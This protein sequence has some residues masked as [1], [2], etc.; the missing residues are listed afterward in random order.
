MTS[1]QQRNEPRRR[2]FVLLTTAVLAVALGMPA[3]LASHPEVSL[4]GSNFEIDTDANLKMDDATPSIDWASVTETRRNDS[5]SGAN[6]ESFGQ[7]TKE[8]TTVPVVVDGGIPPNKSDL[9]AFGVYQEGA[10]S[11]GF[12]NLF[13]SR[14]QDPS[15]TTNMDFE[16]NKNRC[17]GAGCS[18]NGVTP[19]RTAGD[20]LVIYD[21][22]QGGTHPTLSIRRWTGS[23]WGPPTDLSAA[24]DAAGSINTSAIPSADSD[25]LGAL[26]PRTFGEAQLDLAAI[27]SGSTTCTSFGSAYLKSRSSDSFTAALKDFV[28]PVG[29][30]ISNCG[31]VRILKTDDA[32]PANPLSGAVF[33]AYKDAAPTGGSRGAEDSVSAGTCTT[34]AAG[35]CTISSLLTGPYWIVETTTP[36]GFDTAAPQ[37]VD[38]T[39]SQTVTLT[40]VDP[41][42]RGAIRI[43]KTA[44]H[45]DTSGATSPNLV[46]GFTITDSSNVTHTVTTSA[47]GRVCL[48]DLPLGSATVS[49]TTVPA[50]YHAPADVSV[51][52]AKG[53]CSASST[54][55]SASFEN[56]PLTDLTVSV[57]SQVA[58]GTRS[59]ITCTDLSPT[60]ADGTP[61]AFD[62]I[63]ET[64]KDL[65]PGTY[66][67]HLFAR[68]ATD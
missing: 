38:V 68:T 31:S 51:T 37:S 47:T 34:L 17:P 29:I 8:S 57:N 4:A 14:V 21:L 52:V 65:E 13:W 62:D 67:L 7:G 15:G 46:A 18:A 50:G 20:I 25:G 64:V 36:A 11:G 33:T 43:I 35:T 48:A 44:K 55:A 66:G 1:P 5:P 58:G 22:S 26:D 3:A 28:P 60:P 23:A 2:W 45:A 56:T 41:A 10:G 42:Q 9:K 16:F 27:F 6:D 39:A 19:L 53:D 54:A 63:S 49:E 59:K 40:F 12:L 24:S 30:S 32:T 61:T